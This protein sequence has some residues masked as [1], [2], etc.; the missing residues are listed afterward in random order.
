MST[1]QAEINALDKRIQTKE[2]SLSEL[3][4]KREKL[5]QRQ[6]SEY[7][8]EQLRSSGFRGTFTI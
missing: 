2:G 8:A 4:E 5:K 7:L 6:L 3:K 1:T